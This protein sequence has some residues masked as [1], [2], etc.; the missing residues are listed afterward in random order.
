MADWTLEV[1]N[2]LIKLAYEKGKQRASYVNLAYNIKMFIESFRIGVIQPKQ[3]PDLLAVLI[4]RWIAQD[5][6]DRQGM[7][8]EQAAEEMKGVTADSQKLIE[9]VLQSIQP[10][11]EIKND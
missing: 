4:G 2:E 11:Q 7:T 9:I 5:M 6:K 8:P 1:Q 3:M 10:T